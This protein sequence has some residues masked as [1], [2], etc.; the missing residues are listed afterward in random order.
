MTLKEAIALRDSY[1]F[2]KGQKIHPPISANIVDV[3]VVP[4]DSPAQ[5]LSIY[6]EELDFTTESNDELLQNFPSKDYSV[7][8]VSD[9]DP[10]FVD[11]YWEDISSY[12]SRK[13]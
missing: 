11:I 5:F 10:E 2:L 3:I 4:T 12:L 8:V 9:I 6:R 7:H 1:Q 13:S